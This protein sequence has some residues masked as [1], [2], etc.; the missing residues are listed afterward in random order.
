[1]RCCSFL[2]AVNHV[3]MLVESA[4]LEVTACHVAMGG[5]F[6][7]IMDCLVLAAAVVV[8]MLQLL[9]IC[10]KVASAWPCCVLPAAELS[11]QWPS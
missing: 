1:M 2:S 8:G 6:A 7:S 5:M 9:A 4:V 11:D 10:L 3:Q